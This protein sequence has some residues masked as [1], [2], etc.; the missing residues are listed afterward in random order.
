MGWGLFG[1][2]GAGLAFSDAVAVAVAVAVG[3]GRTRQR[4]GATGNRPVSRELS[5]TRRT[6]SESEKVATELADQGAAAGVA[7][8]LISDGTSERRGR[9]DTGGWN[10]DSLGGRG[11]VNL[12]RSKREKRGGWEE[13]WRRQEPRAAPPQQRLSRLE[14]GRESESGCSGRSARGA[15]IGRQQQAVAVAVAAAA[16]TCT[17]TGRA[18][19]ERERG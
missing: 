6:G 17:R 15:T 9:Q 8:R 13:A 12:S 4:A 19:R 3:S 7:C 16:Q 1:E 5:R 18:E 11:C 2:G 14:P 10:D